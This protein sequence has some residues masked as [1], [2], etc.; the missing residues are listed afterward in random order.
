MKRSE[1]IL[2]VLQVPIDFLLLILAGISAYYLRFSEWVVAL[3]P[4]IFEMSIINFLNKLSILSFIFISLINSY[5]HHH[6]Y[7]F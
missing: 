6:I 4:V 3:R 5:I 2:M 1:I 7:F